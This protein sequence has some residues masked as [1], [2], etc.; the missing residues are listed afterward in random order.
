[1]Y[2]LPLHP[3]ALMLAGASSLLPDID[4]PKST[5]GRLVPFLSRPI[6]AVFGHRG[7]THSFFAIL[8]GIMLLS[9]YGYQAVYVAPIVIGYLSHLV[10]DMLN[11]SGVPLFWPAKNR[12]AIPV[13]KTGGLIESIVRLAL[14]GALFW[15]VAVPWMPL[16]GR[17]GV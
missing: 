4:H 14:I 1:M 2:G 17:A 9:K 3:E 6:S 15:M 13:F 16:P 5:F 7:I 8:A 11:K 10:G 12:F